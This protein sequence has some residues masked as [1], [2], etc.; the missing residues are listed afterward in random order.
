[1]SN[2]L[3][4]SAQTSSKARIVRVVGK[5]K[6]VRSSKQ[7]QTCAESIFQERQVNIRIRAALEHLN[8]KNSYTKKTIDI[9]L[10]AFF[11]H[12]SSRTK[13]WPKTRKVMRLNQLKVPH[14]AQAKVVTLTLKLIQ[15][16]LFRFLFGPFFPF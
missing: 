7:R 14:P 15:A 13:I 2:S 11:L 9:K 10:W 3:M 12:V 8:E 1:M 16:W 6:V 5:I 4:S